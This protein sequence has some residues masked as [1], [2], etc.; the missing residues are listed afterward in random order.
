MKT[1][2]RDRVVYPEDGITKG[3]VIDYYEKIADM[4]VPH[5]KNRP[6]M[7]QRF[8]G[9]I[10]AEGFYQKNVSEYFPK[11]I[12]RVT[13]DKA[14]GKV[15]HAIANDA[16]TLVYLANQG[17][18]AFHMW[19]SRTPRL[20]HPDLMIFDL[21]PADDDFRFVKK[22]AFAMRDQ[23]EDLG[24]MSFP[25]TTGSRGL[26]VSVPLAAESDFDT[27]RDF[28]ARIAEQITGQ[29]P[30]RVTMESRKRARH[31]RLFL[32]IMRNAFAQTAVAPY[33][34]RPIAGAPIATP[35]DWD[36]VADSRLHSQ[37]YN[38]KNIF[39][40]LEKR[41]DPWGDIWKHPQSIR[42]AA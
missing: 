25:M 38:L 9:S 6:L 28:A 24:L 26:H 15:T 36:E 41:G 14:G 31:G 35:L 10:Q 42:R 40:R 23:L 33:S 7:L 37:R 3:N 20:K 32:D 1:S 12:K 8:P 17:T 29:F 27:V 34:L 2:N 16:D 5:V 21:D 18:I 13:V 4:M 30:D 11:S 19:L 22:L 39:R